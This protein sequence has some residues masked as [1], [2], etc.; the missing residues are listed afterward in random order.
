MEQIPAHRRPH[1]P[2][3]ERPPTPS[4]EPRGWSLAQTA[5]DSSLHLQRWFPDE[6]PTTRG[7]DARSR[8]RQQIRRAGSEEPANSDFSRLATRAAS[9]APSRPTIKDLI[10]NV[11]CQLGSIS[12]CRST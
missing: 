12:L 10:A 2:P 1:A 6:E 7:R 4:F 3:I 9:R 5:D 8:C 11:P